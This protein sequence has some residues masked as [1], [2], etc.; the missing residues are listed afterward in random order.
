M[1]GSRI[2]IILALVGSLILGTAFGYVF[3]QIFQAN[4]P[5]QWLSSFQANTS[6]FTF[7]GTGTLLGV[8][9]FLWALVVAWLAGGFRKKSKP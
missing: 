7:I 3:L 4:V 6:P 5:Q 1:S 2:G 9:I 8:V